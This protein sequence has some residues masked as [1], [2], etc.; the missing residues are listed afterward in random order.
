MTHDRQAELLRVATH[1]LDRLERALKEVDATPEEV[2]RLILARAV[3]RFD[4]QGVGL[5]GLAACAGKGYAALG[6]SSSPLTPSQACAAVSG[7]MSL[8]AG[9]T[10]FPNTAYQLL[11]LIGDAPPPPPIAEL[12]YAQLS[13]ARFR[14]YELI[15]RPIPRPRSAEDGES[16]DP[17]N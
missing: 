6:K 2:A 12:F 16:K 13:A 10:T 14:I 8:L 9:S 17:A 4:E 3:T 7:A 1:Y 11:A 15:S 5:P